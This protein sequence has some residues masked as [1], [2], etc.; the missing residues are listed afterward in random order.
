MEIGLG[1]VVPKAASTVAA[2]GQRSPAPVV[3]ALGRVTGGVVTLATVAAEVG[4]AVGAVVGAVVAGAGEAAELPHAARL[5]PSNR[6]VEASKRDLLC[7]TL[8][9]SFRH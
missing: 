5:N 3:R 9:A 1:S 7:D 2:V 8:D 6:A 4:A